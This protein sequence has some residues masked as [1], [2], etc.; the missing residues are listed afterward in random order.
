MT[1]RRVVAGLLLV[2]GLLGAGGGAWWLRQLANGCGH[3]SRVAAT[4]AQE[5]E[6]T[7]GTSLRGVLRLLQEKQ[8]VTNARHLEWYLRCSKPDP[9][10]GRGIQAGRYRIEPGH[11]PLEILQQLVEGRVVMEQLTIIEGWTFA[12]MRALLARIAGSAADRLPASATQQIMS[13]LGAPGVAAE[14][15]FAPDTYSY[16]PAA[17]TDMQ[18]LRMAF[19]AQTAE[20]AGGLGSRGSRTCRSPHP[21]KR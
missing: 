2:V 12:Q 9:L 3:R 17:T 19:E 1:T 16:A 11:T 8:L 7:Q 5:F 21:K 18:I 6:I 20:P 10:G 15:R 4:N 14:G 13:E